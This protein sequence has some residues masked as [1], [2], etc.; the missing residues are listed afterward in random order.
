MPVAEFRALILPGREATRVLD[1]DG[2]VRFDQADDGTAGFPE[3]QGAYLPTKLPQVTTCP[4]SRSW[5]A[6]S[7]PR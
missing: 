6:F 7:S 4:V 1:R 5:M 2:T 3:G